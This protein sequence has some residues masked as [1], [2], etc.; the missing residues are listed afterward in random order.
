MKTPTRL[1]SYYGGKSK[2]AHLYPAPRY[3]RIIEPFAGGASYSLRYHD[4][5][6]HLNDF[7]EKT[8]QLW[9]FLI[10]PG[11]L[12]V[13]HRYV[14][15][16]VQQG[17]NVYERVPVRSHPG[18]MELMVSE[19]AQGSYGAKG[20]GKIV[21]EF[22]VKNWN[23]SFMARLDYW[24]PRIAHWTISYGKYSALDDC[25][26]T[27]FVDPPTTTPQDIATFAAPSIFRR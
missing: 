8:F 9:D 19:C 22:G 10:S 17:D 24:L 15:A 25:Y 23:R 4:R 1:F 12:D 3:D 6:V 16:T 21:T 18:L 2:L 11:A 14:P 7:N 5:Q 27:W 20:C 26:A 13:I